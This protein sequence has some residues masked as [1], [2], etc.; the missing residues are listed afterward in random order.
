MKGSG[1]TAAHAV[2]GIRG[3]GKKSHSSPRATEPRGVDLRGRRRGRLWWTLRLVRRPL[4]R[5]TR[6]ALRL[7]DVRGALPAWVPH[8]AQVLVRVPGQ[9]VLH[10]V[11]RPQRHRDVPGPG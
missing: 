3:L 2:L 4:Q 10:A 11:P 1:H 7:Q 6:A 8:T 5:H 9:A